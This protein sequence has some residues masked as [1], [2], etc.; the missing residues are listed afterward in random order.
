MKNIKEKRIVKELWCRVITRG[1]I[2]APR[3]ASKIEEALWLIL[4]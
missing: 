1:V 2:K 3:L 4:S